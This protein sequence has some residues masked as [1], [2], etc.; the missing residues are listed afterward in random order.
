LS[1]FKKGLERKTG[2]ERTTE[3]LIQLCAS[4]PLR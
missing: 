4:V 3:P 1:G 2:N